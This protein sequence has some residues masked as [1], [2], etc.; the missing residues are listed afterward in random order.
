LL[1]PVYT[2]PL[3]GAWIA[4]TYWGRYKTICVAVAIAFVGHVILVASSAP[5]VIAKPDTAIGVLA[6]AIVVMGFGTGM[7]KS[8]IGPL[9][10]EQVASHK[11]TVKTDKKGVKVLVDPAQTAARMFNWYYMCINVGALIGQI[12]MV[13]A[14]RNHGVRPVF[15]LFPLLR[16]LTTLSHS[17]GSP[18]SS[19][20][21]SS[22]PLPSSSTSAATA[23]S[24]P[25]PPVPSSARR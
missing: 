16:V 25:L 18:S 12:G 24:A 22:P 11:L 3:L 13:Y 15:S 21:S 5:S 7:F 8:N 19:L 10:A 6:L 4:D 2:V 20:P 14:E 1:P 9:V 23:T 17:S